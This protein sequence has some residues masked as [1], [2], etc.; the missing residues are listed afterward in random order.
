MEGANDGQAR[1]G[2]GVLI[3][4]VGPSASGKD[5]LIAAARRAFASDARFVFPL[6]VVTRLDQ[7]GEE[8][9]GVSV[10]EFRRM[11][12]EGRLFLSWE[13]Y[14]HSYGIPA[15]V[16]AELRSNRAVVINV[17]R[18][19]VPAARALWTPTHA[20]SIAVEAAVLR[21]RLEARGRESQG[22][23]D[24]RIRRAREER[25]AIAEPVHVLDNSQAL[26]HS[27]P[28]F[29]ALL[30]RLA[31]SAPEGVPADDFERA[32]VEGLA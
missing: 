17:S 30:R 21:R 9:I 4:I 18:E 5:T 20:I 31:A 26:E 24:A 8:H 7:T 1:R 13:A 12:E 16:A 2:S 27:V 19:A 11:R 10:C 22:E 15:N 28:A 3:L 29:L 14:G 6:R 32:S 25:C 23:I